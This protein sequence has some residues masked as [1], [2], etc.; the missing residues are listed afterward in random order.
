VLKGEVALHQHTRCVGG[1]GQSCGGKEELDSALIDAHRRAA[2]CT[3][4][5]DATLRIRD[6]APSP[7]F[8]SP[9]C[10]PLRLIRAA[11]C[12]RS[13]ASSCSTRRRTAS[14]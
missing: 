14:G 5:I 9:I 4:D 11:C 10:A 7:I 12:W 3:G 8:T 6:E 13:V 1:V 2:L